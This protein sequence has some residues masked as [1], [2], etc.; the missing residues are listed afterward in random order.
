MN[1]R[2]LSHLLLLLSGIVLMFDLFPG[3]TVAGH[4]NVHVVSVRAKRNHKLPSSDSS[5]L[6]LV[7]PERAIFLPLILRSPIACNDLED[8]DI[9]GR[10]SILLS[11]N[12]ECNGSL[13]DDP[14]G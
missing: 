12:S 14:Q 4:A 3:H 8:N 11:L 5:T 6:A 7:V 10:A 9:P 2:Q 13:Q 1:V